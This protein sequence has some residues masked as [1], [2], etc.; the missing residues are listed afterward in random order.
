MELQLYN[1][2]QIQQ[3]KQLGRIPT[4]LLPNKK[5]QTYSIMQILP[6]EY[7]RSLCPKMY[8]DVF[9]SI[10]P[11]LAL[12]KRELGLIGARAVLFIIISHEA[13]QYNTGQNMD[14]NQMAT[15]VDDVLDLFYFLKI[16]DLK[17]CF[18][19]ARIGRYGQ[20]FRLDGSVV[21]SWLEKYKNERLNQADEVSYQQHNSTKGDKVIMQFENAQEVYEHFKQ[22]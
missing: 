1:N 13:N 8:T 11:S 20:V 10:L 19:N 22:K 6:L 5:E 15:L 2:D 9:D 7:Y 18:D 3:I 16:D 17:L 21:L 14:E 4:D 12:C